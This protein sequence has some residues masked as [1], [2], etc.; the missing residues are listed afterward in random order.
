[1]ESLLLFKIKGL[2]FEARTGRQIDYGKSM[3][4]CKRE[5]K[6]ILHI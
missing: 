4:N 3:G 1:M 5:P 2:G 6:S